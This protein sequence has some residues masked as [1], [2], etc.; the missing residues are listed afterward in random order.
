MQ[1]FCPKCGKTVPEEKM[2]NNFCLNCYVEDHQVITA[3]TFEITVCPKCGKLRYAKKFFETKE[4][5]E[6]EMTKHIRVKDIEQAKVSV[7]L[8]IDHDKHEFYIK[9]LAKAL[10]ANTIQEIEMEKDISLRVEPCEDCLKLA[11]NYYTTIL[12]LRFDTNK[13]MK[14]LMPLLIKQV[15]LQVR[16]INDAEGSK[17]KPFFIA[18]TVDQKTGI[19]FYL[20]DPDHT[21]KLRKTLLFN[22]HAKTWQKTRS[23]L[24]ADK[25]GRRKYRHTICIHFGILETEE[26]PQELPERDE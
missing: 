18:K 17:H 5:L 2:I 10:I 14:D 4:A 8:I 25:D 16:T 9:A 13:L 7:E 1:R 3:P 19:D 11:S 20:N 12:Q 6:H 21:E 26:T 15:Q 24:T 23:L 22:K